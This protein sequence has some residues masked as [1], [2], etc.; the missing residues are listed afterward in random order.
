MT[1]FI[2]GRIVFL[3]YMRVFAFVSVLVGHKFFNYLTGFANDAN[4]HATIRAVAELLMPLCQG[5]A[6][7]VV[8][9]FLTSGYI[10]T[11]VLQKEAAADFLIKRIFRIY[12]L[13]IAA[14]VLEMLVGNLISQVPLPNFDV[15]MQRILLIGDFY[16]T[17]YALAGVEWTLRIEIMFY[18]YMFVIKLIGAFRFQRII[19][20]IH[21]AAAYGLFIMPAFPGPG[22]WTEGYFNAY[23]PFLLIGSLLYLAQQKMASRLLC[24]LG[25]AT[26]IYI[27]M[28]V[29]ADYQPIW[30]VSHYAIYAA[31]I[32]LIA[33]I[34]R[35]RLAD[36]KELRLLSDL[37]YSVYLF[38]NW[39]W[40]YIAIPFKLMGLIGIWEQI[41]I[42][43]SLLAFC[44]LMH[45]TVENIG[46]KLGR[47]M[48]NLMRRAEANIFCRRAASVEIERTS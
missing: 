37:T 21:A 14:I 3:D 39:A 4:Q 7:G 29:I 27:S 38:H 24:V 20:L 43:V 30:K 6:A 45:R 2:K 33:F 42:T 10:I 41:A 26:M 36:S 16:D 47:P 25:M 13:Y 22:I 5:G 15:F 8:V 48:I 17:P 40:E 11:H 1:D 35:D 19:P 23:A 44:Y 12:P 46:I 31:I 34:F 28:K 18:L 32:F 9:F